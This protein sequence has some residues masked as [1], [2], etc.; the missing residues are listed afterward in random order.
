MSN[1]APLASLVPL[2]GDSFNISNYEYV[3]G[4]G[5]MT[6]TQR[7]D[8]SRTTRVIDQTPRLQRMGRDYSVTNM[9]GFALGASRLELPQ[10]LDT[11]KL[12]GRFEKAHKLLFA[13][14]VR[15]LSALG[16]HIADPRL[17]IVQVDTNA[18][19]VFRILAITAEALLG[20]ITVFALPLLF[21]PW[22]C[23]SQLKKDPASFT[24]LVDLLTC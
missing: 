15:G 13:L 16:A 2:K 1:V 7:F 17:G 24:D 14:A 20:L 12:A 23:Q 4:T 19:V 8:I 11:E 18:I 22:N 5:A 10:Y 9:V 6:N 3:I 21:L